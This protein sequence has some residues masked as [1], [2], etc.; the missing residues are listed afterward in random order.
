MATICN[1]NL[2][3]VIS[4]MNNINIWINIRCNQS[5]YAEVDCLHVINRNRNTMLIHKDLQVHYQHKALMYCTKIYLVFLQ[6]K[7]TIK[8]FEE[9]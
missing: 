2:S 5:I 3:N 8:I 1:V 7:K 9:L 6:E 4:V